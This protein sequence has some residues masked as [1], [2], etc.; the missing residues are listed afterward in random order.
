MSKVLECQASVCLEHFMGHSSV[1]PT[2]QF[3]YRKGQGTCDTLLCVSH[4]LQSALESGQ[5]ARIEATFDR[6]KI[7]EFSISS[8]PRVLKVLCC[9]Y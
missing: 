3:T 1:L 4:T 8:A 2:T 6:V 7:R 9:R 5:E